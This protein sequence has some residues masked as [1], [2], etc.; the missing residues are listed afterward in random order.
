MTIP[1]GT[2]VIIAVDSET[3]DHG[4]VCGVHY[5]DNPLEWY[6]ICR[7]DGRPNEAEQYSCHTVRWDRVSAA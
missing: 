7:I 3:T 1:E 4:S 2:R 6:Y 5:T